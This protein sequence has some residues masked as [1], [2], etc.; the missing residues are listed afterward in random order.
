MLFK[1]FIGLFPSIFNSHYS[2]FCSFLQLYNID[3]F[4]ISIPYYIESR[5]FRFPYSTRFVY[6]CPHNLF[7]IF[8]V[9][10]PIARCFRQSF[11]TSLF[12]TS[13]PIIHYYNTQVF[14]P[15]VILIIFNSFPHSHLSLFHLY[16]VVDKALEVTGFRSVLT[17]TSL[18]G[19][20][21][22]CRNF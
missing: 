15:Y 3:Y 8:I 16:V 7:Y 19:R 21:I 14:P 11:D 17:R 5:P 12:E 9:T 2:L 6:V 22:I 18:Y 20:S 10:F 1:N 13:Q 4:F